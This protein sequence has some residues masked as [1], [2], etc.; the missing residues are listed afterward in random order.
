M[1]NDERPLKIPLL[2][3]TNREG[4]ESEKAAR[5]VHRKMAERG[6][7]SKFFDVAEFDLPQHDYGTALGKEFPEW[8]D[9]IIEADGLVIVSR[10]A[11]WVL[12][13]HLAER[14]SRQLL[15]ERDLLRLLRR[16]CVP[17]LPE[18]DDP[19]PRQCNPR[20]DARGD[21]RALRR[22]HHR[23]GVGL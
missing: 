13:Q 3:G 10:L 11:A 16:L 4:R 21:R 6:I 15:V 22:G 12:L 7:D 20:R 2:L 23:I 17:A 19:Q 5:W 9:A 8:R 18:P 14:V 1:A